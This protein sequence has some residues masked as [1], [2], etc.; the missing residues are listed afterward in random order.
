MRPGERN[1]RTVQY[2]NWL[3][4]IS[5][6]TLELQGTLSLTP[7]RFLF[8]GQGDSN[9]RLRSSFDRTFGSEPLPER[10]RKYDRIR[11]KFVELYN[12]RYKDNASEK[13]I[14]STGQHF[15]LP[16]RLLDWSSNP[17][18]AAYFAFNNAALQNQ[19]GGRVAVWAIDTTNP[20]VHGDLGLTVFQAEKNVRAEA[21]GGYFSHLT[22]PFDDL[23]EYAELSALQTEPLLFRFLLPVSEARVAFSYLDAVG[24]NA[25]SLFPDIQGLTFAALEEEWLGESMK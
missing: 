22:G 20:L 8:R 3:S 17:F 18:V 11:Q 12:R 15:G 5:K 13:E 16:T 21:Q 14:L 23:E 10:L 9:Y 24:F 1:I 2:R 25:Y 6:F 7:K 4:F 19:Q